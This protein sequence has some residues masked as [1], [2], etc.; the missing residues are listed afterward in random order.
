MSALAESASRHAHRPRG[1]WIALALSLTLNVFV[2]GGL[3]WAMM[4]VQPIES[5]AQRFVAVG[6]SLDLSDAQRAA[7]RQFGVTAREAVGNLHHSNGP[8]MRKIWEEMA[9]PQPDQA[10]IAALIDQSSQYRHEYLMRMT[11]GLLQFLA[12]L[13]PDQR[14]RFA[15]LAHRPHPA[16]RGG[17]HFAL[18]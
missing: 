1:L 3:V 16:A 17:W 12:S 8:V 10:A 14:A 7:L 11:S 15:A 6:R 13:T 5:P 2:I 9:K 4:E 18:P